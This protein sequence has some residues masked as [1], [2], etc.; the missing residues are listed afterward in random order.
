M[1]VKYLTSKEIWEVLSDPKYE[2]LLSKIWITV[3]EQ[4]ILESASAK[5][6]CEVKLQRDERS[7]VPQHS[8]IWVKVK[9]N[10]VLR[11]TSNS[12]A[13]EVFKT[14][15]SKE[16][17]ITFLD[18]LLVSRSE[19]L[20]FSR[21]K[22]KEST[23]ENLKQ[24]SKKLPAAQR[25]SL[26]VYKSR[27]F[28]IMN[29]LWNLY[30]TADNCDLDFVYNILDTDY[31]DK[32]ADVPNEELVSRKAQKRLK[33]MIHDTFEFLN[34]AKR[35]PKNEA[36]FSKIP[37]INLDNEKDFVK[38]IVC[39]MKNME[40]IDQITAPEE[41]KMF[42]GIFGRSEL[43]KVSNSLMASCTPD[44]QTAIRFAMQYSDGMST[45]GS[46]S[47]ITISVQEGMPIIP[48]FF[49]VK[50]T[51]RG[52]DAEDAAFSGVNYNELPDDAIEIIIE[53][54]DNI[55]EE[56]IINSGLCKMPDLTDWPEDKVESLREYR[57][58]CAESERF[59]FIDKASGEEIQENFHLRFDLQRLIRDEFTFNG[60]QCC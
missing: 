26:V 28:S 57:H 38:T 36:F 20:Y 1:E 51:L 16:E 47:L 44:L 31:N 4:E 3:G 50:T 33:V 6:N 2:N 52:V 56:I 23:K 21:Y 12:K 39:A 22:L 45:E 13:N 24:Q 54:S 37:N 29:T 42:R 53:E 60:Q 58:S 41:L 48:M 32:F 40:S 19:L 43:S 14:F 25:E 59:I 17:L 15:Q 30:K 55:Q 46:N 9:T 27:M 7:K 49:S 18:D 11:Q 5:L 8:G 34:K 35:N 10:P